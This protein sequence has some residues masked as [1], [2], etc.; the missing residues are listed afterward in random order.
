MSHIIVSKDNPPKVY[1]GHGWSEKDTDALQYATPELA[2]NIIAKH[3]MQARVVQTGTND[4]DKDGDS[5]DTVDSS[6]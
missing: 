5:P 1:T 2:Q 4:L 6:K 3:N